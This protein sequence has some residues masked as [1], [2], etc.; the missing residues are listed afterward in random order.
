[1]Q[2]GPL[3]AALLVWALVGL[4]LAYWARPWWQ[5]GPVPLPPA[6]APALQV[7]AEQVA[8]ALGAVSVAP[9][10]AMQGEP[11]P[12]ATALQ[13]QGVVSDGQGR[14]VALLAEAGQP[15]RALRVG[16]AM[17]DGWVL[18]SLSATEAVLAAPAGHSGERRLALPQAE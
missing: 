14:G 2:A 11:Q 5:S 4:S 16:Q 12:T 15:A 1:M 7:Q 6:A 8:R 3:L 9:N 10:L 17:P 13:L 18:Q